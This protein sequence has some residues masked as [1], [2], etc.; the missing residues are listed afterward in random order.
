M[1]F[2]TACASLLLPITL[3]AVLIRITTRNDPIPKPLAVAL[4]YGLGTGILTHWMVIANFTGMPLSA[5][6]INIPLGIAL[7]IGIV[8]LLRQSRSVRRLQPNREP[9]DMISIVCGLVILF[10]THFILWRALNFPIFAWDTFSTMGLKG[11]SIYYDQTI[12]NLAFIPK[13]DYPIH[14]PLLTAWISFC[15][16][17]WNNTLKILFPL[18]CFFYLVIQYYFLREFAA[19]RWAL[20]SVVFLLSCNFL[21]YHATITYRDIHMMYF[22]CSTLLLIAWWY[23]RQSGAWLLLSAVFAGLTSFIKLEGFGYMVLYNLLMTVLIWYRNAESARAKIMKNLEFALISGGIY[24]IYLIYRIFHILPYAAGRDEVHAEHFYINKINLATGAELLERMGVVLMRYIENFFMSGN[25][26]VIPILFVLSLWQIFF[27]RN[28]HVGVVMLLFLGLFF[29]M[30]FV[31]FSATQHYVWV[32]KQ[33]H[34]LSRSILHVFP[35]LVTLTI[36]L[37]ADDHSKT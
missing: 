36:L 9:P 20:L 13:F 29:G 25:W 34:V 16:G 24:A 15:M 4:G 14:I 11:K 31:T 26:N 27:S 7:V 6:V 19:R 8:S 1:T 35:I 21:I 18:P 30:Y 10:V 12:R 23:R 32:A 37:N 5:P 17:E 28:R 2:A 33:H 3:G 22:N